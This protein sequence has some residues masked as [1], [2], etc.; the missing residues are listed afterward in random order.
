MLPTPRPQITQRQKKRDSRSQTSTPTIASKKHR[1]NRRLCVVS[2]ELCL[3]P[4]PNRGQSDSRLEH[5]GDKLSAKKDGFIRIASRN[6]GGLGIHAH[7][8]K[9]EHLKEWIVNSDIDCIG[10]QEININ[11]KHCQYR[12]RIS[13]RMKCAAW[14]FFKVST[15]YN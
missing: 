9:E 14:K 11:V 5:W 15:G 2:N 8:T 10:L 4:K 7:N 3:E 1:A 6:I 12:D 13:E